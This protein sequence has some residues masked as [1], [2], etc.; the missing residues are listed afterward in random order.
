[1]GP[2]GIAFV[3]LLALSIVKRKT[4]SQHWVYIRSGGKAGQRHLG[5]II[6]FITISLILIV[7]PIFLSVILSLPSSKYP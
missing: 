1:M 5:F 6:P 2:T 4:I 3:L 7:V